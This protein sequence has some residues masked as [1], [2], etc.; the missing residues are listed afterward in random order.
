[1]WIASKYGFFSIV[2][3]KEGFHVRG[4]SLKDLKNLKKAAS[5][6]YEILERVGT[7][8]AY[9]IIVDKKGLKK[10]MSAMEESI[11]YKNFKNKIHGIKDQKS[12][13]HAYSNLW[14]DLYILQDNCYH[15]PGSASQRKE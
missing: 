7:D 5:I 8:Y 13:V 9:R 6:D 12:K 15:F 14:A 11:D 1:M 4:R 3:K 2:K 10:V